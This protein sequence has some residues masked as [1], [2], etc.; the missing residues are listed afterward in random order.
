VLAHANL[1]G[2]DLWNANL[3]GANL[4][5]AYLSG[6]DRRGANLQDAD[7]TAAHLEAHLATNTSEANWD[8]E[9]ITGAN[10]SRAKLDG[11]DLTGIYSDASTQWPKG[12]QP[13]PS[14]PRPGPSL[15]DQGECPKVRGKVNKNVSP[16]TRQC[17][18]YACR[19]TRGGKK[20]LD[21]SVH[22]SRCIRPATNGRSRNAHNHSDPD[23]R[24][25]HRRRRRA[26]DQ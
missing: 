14:R 5:E 16:L 2:A 12:F 25:H 3:S 10:L 17:D 11:A 4:T 7:L 21:V 19:W 26:V 1:A 13:P 24:H 15:S 20:L 6:A 22:Y 23:R 18:P 8:G 9:N